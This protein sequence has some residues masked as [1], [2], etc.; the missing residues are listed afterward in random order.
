[1]SI[2]EGSAECSVSPLE[3]F[4]TPPT[5]TAVEKSYDVEF[6][7]TSALRHSGVVEFY[8]PASA[9]DY[10]DF[11]NSRLYIRAKIVRNDGTDVG[12][13]ERVAPVNNL[14]QTMWSNVELLVNERLVT[15]SN[16]MHGYV[17][18]LSHLMH[19][20]D[21]MLTS[22]R[23]M[24]M[25]YKDTAGSLDETNC[26]LP[27]PEGLIAGHS[28]RWQTHGELVGAADDDDVT[29]NLENRAVAIAADTAVGNHGLHLRFSKTRTSQPFEMMGN[30]RLDLMQQLRYLPNGLAL[31]LRLHQQKGSFCLMCPERQ[32]PNNQERRYR[33]ELLNACFI[34]RRIKPSTGVL[35]GHA[36]ALAKKP[37]E[38]P[39]IR[40]E[41]KSFAIPAGIM[42][43]KQDNIFLGQLPTRVIVAMVRGVAFAGSFQYNPYRFHHYNASLVQVY[44]DGEPVRSRPFRPNIADGQFVE[45]YNSLYSEFG[46]V[47][48]DR[49]SIIKLEDW[50]RGYSL[51]AFSL[52]PDTDCDD[53]TSLVKHGNLR[54]E[55]Q[56]SDTLEHAI[57]LLVYAEFDNVIKIDSN[58]QLLIDYV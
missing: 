45:C 14:L 23:Q 18:M 3:L 47:D 13:G 36:D 57:Q 24:Q 31:K 42:Q 11:K 8:M 37:A 30:V 21:E 25:I 46:K 43:F 26:T 56:F 44:A 35:L 22:E 29:L 41:C 1:M 58:R 40:K 50:K 20:S 2:R 5:Q 52:S 19:D 38:F 15:H 12:E 48:G 39:V 53:H 17:S 34:A 33:L 54:V 51:F 7:P 55:V 10:L 28:Y 27:N 6:L 16:N 49:G 32:P 4:D 9:E